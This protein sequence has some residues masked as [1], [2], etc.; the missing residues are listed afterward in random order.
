M[1]SAFKRTRRLPARSTSTLSPL[2]P[3]V[4][5]TSAGAAASPDEINTSKYI[6]ATAL[7]SDD[8][9]ENRLEEHGSRSFPVGLAARRQSSVLINHRGSV[10]P[11]ASIQG[12]ELP[13][14]VSALT[15]IS[16][17]ET[18]VSLRARWICVIARIIWLIYMPLCTTLLQAFGCVDVSTPVDSRALPS[19]SFSYLKVEPDIDCAQTSYKNMIVV[20]AFGVIL[21]LLGIPLFFAYV[22]YRLFQSA[23]IRSDL[24]ARFH[25]QVP[26]DDDQL[27]FG[28][29]SRD[30]GPALSFLV[31][32]VHSKMWWWTISHDVI[33]TLLLVGCVFII[34]QDSG[35]VPISVVMVCMLSALLT[36]RLR[37]YTSELFSWLEAFLMSHIA[38]LVLTS[39]LANNIIELNRLL[40]TSQLQSQVAGA[41][42]SRRSVMTITPQSMQNIMFFFDQVATIMF[43]A[44]GASLEI[45]E[46][47][48][49]VQQALAAG[50]LGVCTFFSS[51]FGF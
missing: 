29:P 6:D 47:I 23:Q 15:L 27:V 14:R 11:V 49:A 26:V 19:F 18:P 8:S 21:Y 2:V 9:L 3:R 38:V 39:L 37:P 34:P 50:I 16:N 28:I 13:R 12:R 10:A 20:A 33:R 7:N 1:C 43:I 30:W 31:V 22:E 36:L 4:S 5:N 42:I 51:F 24:D 32:C 45:Y 17:S 25:V 46:R 44:I 41:I 40:S 48:P 35:M